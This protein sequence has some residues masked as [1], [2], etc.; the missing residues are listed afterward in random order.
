MRFSIG[1]DD[2]GVVLAVSV[3]GGDAGD[4]VPGP[5]MSTR[6]FDVPDDMPEA[7]Q[8]QV[9]ERLLIDTDPR[10]LLPRDGRNQ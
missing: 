2:N 9:V 1:Y 3:S 4:S 10:N 8:R 7:E 6:H 5:G